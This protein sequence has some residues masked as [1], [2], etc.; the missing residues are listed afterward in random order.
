MT[1]P[2]TQ[3]W[4]ESAP[5][6]NMS[7]LAGS[8]VC[9]GVFANA[10]KAGLESGTSVSPHTIPSEKKNKN[11][12]RKAILNHNTANMQLIIIILE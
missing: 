2:I 12:I 5:Q 9:V 10:G 11:L 7:P 3:A 8:I 6:T 4:K 1:F